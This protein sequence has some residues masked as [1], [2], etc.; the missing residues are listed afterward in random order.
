M[1]L[2]LKNA[3]FID[4]ETLDFKKSHIHVEPGEKGKL[5][6]VDSIP[7]KTHADQV[8]DCEGKYVTKSFGNAHHHSYSALARGMPPP[9][10]TPENFYEILKYIWWNLDKNLDIDIIEASALFT[11][12]ESL[13]SGVTFVIDHHSSPNT[14]DG[15]LETI[16]GAFEFVGLSHLLCYEVSDR[17]GMQTSLE[18]FAETGHYLKTAQGLAGLHASFTVSDHTLKRAAQLIQKYKTGI[19]IHVAEDNYDQN[20]CKTNYKQRVVERLDN[21]NLVNNPKSILAHCLHLDDAEKN[22]IRKSAAWVAQ[23]TESNLNNGVGHFNAKG[24]GNNIMLGTDGMHSDMIRSA[25]YAWFSGKEY[26]NISPAEIYRR[27]RNIHYYLE[28]N[29]YKG[30]GGNNLVVLDYD[31]PTD[32]NKE[33]FFGHFIYG[34]NSNHVQHVISKGEVVVRDHKLT[35]MNEDDILLYAREMAKKLWMDMKK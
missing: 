9:Q 11:A 29:K 22:I 25:Q 35:G 1:G 26:E 34:I 6:F 13:K 27:F 28:S 24:L 3:T 5:Y 7:L 31:P 19:H 20:H 14:I 12:A 10:S 4:W 17:D 8:I 16:A 32:L 30:D 21:F 15:S 2:Y 33:N 18:G 23:N